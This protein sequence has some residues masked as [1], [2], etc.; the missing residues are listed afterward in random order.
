MCNCPE[1][2]RLVLQPGIDIIHVAPDAVRPHRIHFNV[3]YQGSDIA[4][5]RVAR[6]LYP[7]SARVH[8]NAAACSCPV[9]K[10]LYVLRAMWAAC[11]GRRKARTRTAAACLGSGAADVASSGSTEGRVLH[12]TG[13]C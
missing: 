5:G 9:T 1:L 13:M 12:G 10:R 11:S 4:C 7:A 6:K 3:P 2:T 8:H